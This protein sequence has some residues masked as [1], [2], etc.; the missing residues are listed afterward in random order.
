ME[1]LKGLRDTVQ[2]LEK[3]HQIHILK[4]FKTYK[5]PYTENSN[6]I[7]VNMK[8]LRPDVLQHIEKYLKYVNLQE[9]HLDE[10]EAERELYK[11][12][13]MKKD[14]KETLQCYDT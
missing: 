7:F 13:F 12:N 3:I 6:G 14:N 9:D 8:E 4:I 2:N 11:I 1:N 10:G 5:V